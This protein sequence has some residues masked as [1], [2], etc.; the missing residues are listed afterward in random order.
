M[1]LPARADLI[2]QRCGLVMVLG[3]GLRAGTAILTCNAV[4]DFE[5]SSVR[6]GGVCMALQ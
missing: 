2:L 6:G 1:C 4:F 3:L 5:S